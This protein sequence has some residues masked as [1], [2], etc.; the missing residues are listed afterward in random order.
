M[1]RPAVS[2]LIPAYRPDWLDMAVAS[3]LAQTHADFELLVSDDTAGDQ[4]ASIMS[5]WD[6][7]RVCYFRNPKVGEPGSNRNNLLERARG[8][9]VKFLFDD[10]FLLPQ[11]VERLLHAARSN[12]A[13]MAFHDR[14]FIDRNGCLLGSPASVP[15]GTTTVVEPKQ[16]FEQ[17]VGNCRNLIGEP[18]NIL[19]HTATLRSMPDPFALD[20]RRMHFLTDVALY[21]NFFARS[22]RV[23]GIGW[24]GSAF[25][26]HGGQ[27]SGA[28]SP[29]LS[30]GYFEWELLRRWSVDAGLLDPLLYQRTVAALQSMYQTQVMNY[31]ELQAFIDMQGRA[32]GPRYLSNGFLETLSV[33]YTAIEMRKLVATEASASARLH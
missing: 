8:D 28:S 16:F 27:A 7:P 31:P 30:A 21:T 33:A 20:G 17:L 14:H 11:S 24:C 5:K 19:L 29:G 18:T 26:Q 13:Q 10:D 15:A 12:Q 1:T 6:D 3:A 9:Y 22:Q 2:I 25:R 4:I 23:V 32:D